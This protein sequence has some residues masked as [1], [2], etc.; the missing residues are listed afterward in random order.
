A[1]LVY[2]D[3]GDVPHS[4]S[5]LQRAQEVAREYSRRNPSSRNWEQLVF[6]GRFLLANLKQAENL[7]EA[8]KE[9]EA[10]ARQMQPLIRD[11]TTKDPHNA[12]WKA[13]QVVL[14][15]VRGGALAALA[16]QG[17]SPKENRAEALRQLKEALSLAEELTRLDPDCFTFCRSRFNVHAA[18]HQLYA[19]LGEKELAWDQVRK[20]AQVQLAFYQ[21]YADKEPDQPAWQEGLARAHFLA[22]NDW[23]RLHHN[24]PEAAAQF[25]QAVKLYEQLAR[26]EPDRPDWLREQARA[27]QYLGRLLGERA[28]RRW[29]IKVN[30][31]S[32]LQRYTQSQELAE[33]LE[34][35]RQA[36]TVREKFVTL[37]PRNPRGW[38]ELA[39][40]Y[41]L[42][43]SYSSQKDPARSEALFQKLLDTMEKT[44]ALDPASV[45][46][47]PFARRAEASTFLAAVGS[48]F[49]RQNAPL[50]RRIVVV[51]DALYRG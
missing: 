5:Y 11:R 36:I 28:A 29:P 10:T 37:Q 42:L 1:A 4:L 50:N 26:R 51:S 24:F 34:V 30:D 38:E 32:S 43:G 40:D 12:E 16:D 17:I 15:W 47:D 23:S 19:S 25:R 8:L 49:N 35:L 3:R 48:F 20:R 13:Q 46:A 33:G 7:I 9:Q 2:Q 44:I 21:R 14:G 18:L 27:L 39:E 6:Q 22:G 31:P 41:R 45:Q